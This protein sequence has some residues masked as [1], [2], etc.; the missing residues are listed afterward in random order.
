MALGMHRNCIRLASCAPWAVYA[1]LAQSGCALPV[2]NF[3][4]GEHPWDTEG[5]R[6]QA[7]PLVLAGEQMAGSPGQMTSLRLLL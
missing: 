5:C 3:A 4:R 2:L 6:L 1:A 7:A